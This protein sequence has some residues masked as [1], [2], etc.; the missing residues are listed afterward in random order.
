MKRIICI[1]LLA[2]SALLAGCG[3]S[4]EEIA[5]MTAAAW[6]PTSPPTETPI[7]MQLTVHVT[8]QDGN[9]V[10]KANLVPPGS[11]VEKPVTADEAGEAVLN[12]VP[13]AN[14]TLLVSAA[15]YFAAQQDLN[16][17]P[18][19][20][21]LTVVLQRDPNGLSGS[22]ACAA[23]ENLLFIDDF[24][25]GR[26]MNW[27]VVRLQ[28]G[29]WSTG[30]APDVPENLVMTLNLPGSYGGRVS[31]NEFATPNSGPFDNAVV[32]YRTW[33]TG[34]GSYIASW[35]M[36]T[37]PYQTSGGQAE[38]GSRYWV[39][40]GSDPDGRGPRTT[41]LV[42]MQPPLSDFVVASRA[43]EFLAVNTWHFVEI[44]TFDGVT[45]IWLDGSEIMNY[46][47]PEPLPSGIL[48][49][50]ADEVEQ[51]AIAY[52]D[53]IRVCGLNAPNTSMYAP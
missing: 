29:G 51:G 20:N 39:I 14:G 25:D 19:S 5:T 1:P 53:D 15:G 34:P 50:A 17:Q 38:A 24:Q 45:S 40:L 44:G 49:F 36:A 7:P 33:I 6:T 37:E 28:A 13:S 11:S 43:V 4:A 27:E 26:A 52:F 23:G 35:R 30:P 16:L 48:G 12:N 32:R 9:P 22:E 41:A 18:G 3:P 2:V 42:R 47:D 46:T 31:D 10:V 8:D 21:E